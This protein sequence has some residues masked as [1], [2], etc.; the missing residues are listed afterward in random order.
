MT[1]ADLLENLV[2]QNQGIFPDSEDIE[3]LFPEIEPLKTEISSLPPGQ[4][5]L[6]AKITLNSDELSFLEQKVLKELR[7][8][9]QAS[10]YKKRAE[11][12]EKID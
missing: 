10:N 5:V 9:K 12:L 3:K 1:R 8:G 7:L 6:K 11:E 4:S 2:R